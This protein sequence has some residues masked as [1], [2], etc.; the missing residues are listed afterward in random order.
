MKSSDF[1][2]VASTL[3]GSKR[4]ESDS[5]RYYEE[6]GE[7]PFKRGTFNE[8]KC[9]GE[10]LRHSEDQRL[11]QLV[12]YNVLLSCHIKGYRPSG[13]PL[14]RGRVFDPQS[15]RKSRKPLPPALNG[16]LIS[17]SAGSI[18]DSTEIPDH[19]IHTYASR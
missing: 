14:V 16:S 12:R 2:I 17:I 19:V 11:D 7:T 1:A 10:R 4:E 5:P 15:S 13:R 8:M 3:S 18:R 6:R 9:T